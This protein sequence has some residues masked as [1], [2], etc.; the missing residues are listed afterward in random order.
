MGKSK[1]ALALQNELIKNG[2][3]EALLSIDVPTATEFASLHNNL[4]CIKVEQ[5][6]NDEILMI[7]MHLPSR[8]LLI[9]K[10]MH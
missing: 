1:D 6:R 2:M 7:C 5:L 3:K 8:C 9:T 4:L 10:D